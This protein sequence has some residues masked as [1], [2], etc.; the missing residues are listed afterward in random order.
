MFRSSHFSFLVFGHFRRRSYKNTKIL[1]NHCLH[2][3]RQDGQGGKNRKENHTTKVTKIPK[4]RR[5]KYGMNKAKKRTNFEEKHSLTLWSKIL[6]ILPQA[7]Y[8]TNMVCFE[9]ER[10]AGTSQALRCFS[11]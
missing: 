9:V 10:Q 3:A 5:R 7:R 6:P 8:L 1:R 2:F 11:L 4:T